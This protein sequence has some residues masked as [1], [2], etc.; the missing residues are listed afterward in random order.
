MR[1]RAISV[2]INAVHQRVKMQKEG[3]LIGRELRDARQRSA[4]AEEVETVKTKKEEFER[5]KTAF[6]PMTG[7]N[8]GTTSTHGIGTKHVAVGSISTDDTGSEVGDDNTGGRIKR[9]H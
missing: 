6:R 8:V 2:P 5:E 1:G 4:E 3:A 9:R 7:R